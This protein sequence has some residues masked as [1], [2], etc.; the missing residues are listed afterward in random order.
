[1]S[2]NLR[3][4]KTALGQNGTKLEIDYKQPRNLKILRDQTK[5]F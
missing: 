4:Q 3:E 2:I 1:M 5:H